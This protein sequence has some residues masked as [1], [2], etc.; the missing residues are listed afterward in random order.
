MQLHLPPLRNFLDYSLTEDLGIGGDITSNSLI[1]EKQIIQFSIIS[2]EPMIVCGNPIVE[3]FF[4]NH[5]TIKYEFS[6]KDGEQIAKGEKIVSGTGKAIEILMLE[7]TILNYLQHLSGIATLTNEYVKKISHSKAKICDTRKTI[8]GLRSLQKYA[9]SCGGGCNH[10][11]ALDSSILIKDNHLAI[12][13]S[14]ANSLKKAKSFAPHY[15]KIEIECDTLEQVKQAINCQ[16]DVIMLD[17]MTLPQIYEAVRLINNNSLIEVS[18]GINLENLLQIADTGV[19]FI[20]V[21]RLT[22]SAR[23][24]DIGLDL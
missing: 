4:N 5:S 20:S 21:G 12:C 3:Y 7:R 9:V 10:R 2:R 15:T 16:V 6:A 13:G 23:A 19:D 22:N 18:G 8:P 14:I 1:D 17:N 11:F 24:I